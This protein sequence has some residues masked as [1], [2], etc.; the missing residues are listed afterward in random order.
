M[1]KILFVLLLFIPFIV[2]AENCEVVTG[3]ASIA[4]VL[5]LKK[6]ELE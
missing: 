3:T 5:L 6:Q 4:T 2:L 1:K